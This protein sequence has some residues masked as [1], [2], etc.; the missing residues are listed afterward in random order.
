MVFLD[1]HCECSHGWLQPLLARIENS[2][3]AVV[4]PLIDVISPKTFEYQTEGYSFDVI[5]THFLWRNYFLL[6]FLSN[7]IGGFTW[8]GHFDWHD[9]PERERKRQRRECK[10]EIEICPTMSP[11]MA[12]GLFAIS[13]DYFWEIGS[14]DE[15]MDGWGGE[16]L[17]MV[18]AET[19]SVK[20]KVF[21]FLITEFSYL[22]V[23]GNI[24]NNP[25]FKNRSH[26]PRISSLQFSQ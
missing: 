15:Q 14:Y 16:N 25:M 5:S 20:R 24:G 19:K 23:R 2:R 11:T 17:E 26:F 13:R 10:D 8:D 18:K 7:K 12:G 22:A 21:N 6:K 3:K 9:V 1:A 4:V